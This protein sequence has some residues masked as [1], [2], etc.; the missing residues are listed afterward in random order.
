MPRDEFWTMKEAPQPVDN[1]IIESEIGKIRFLSGITNRPELFLYAQNKLLYN[2]GGGTQFHRQG[3]VNPLGL[4]SETDD[5]YRRDEHELPH[6]T[7]RLPR[8][9]NIGSGSNT[10]DNR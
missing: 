7:S 10:S 9:L 6:I 1:H 8:I 3:D 4:P 5:F 2:E